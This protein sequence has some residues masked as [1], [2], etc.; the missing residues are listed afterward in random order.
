VVVLTES[1]VLNDNRNS[2][3]SKASFEGYYI[4]NSAVILQKFGDKETDEN[5][6]EIL[7]KQFPNRVIEQ[8]AI[9]GIASG[10]GSIHCATQQ[11]HK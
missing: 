8:I 10:G 2:N 5:A 6:F 4:C 9:N 7:Q 3:I 11:E 1:S